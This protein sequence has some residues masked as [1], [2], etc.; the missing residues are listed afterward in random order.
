MNRD[1]EDEKIR[2]WF[3]E[4]KRGDEKLA[5]SFV[6]DWEAARSHV[7]D[8]SQFFPFSAAAV[9][10]MLVFLAAFS[11][12]L[13]RQSARPESPINS[14]NSTSILHWQAPTDFLLQT[15]GNQLLRTAPQIGR[16]AVELPKIN[17][18]GKSR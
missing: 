7:G 12:I 3:H 13:V 5:P 17:F 6:C 10:V 1:R 4:L 2:Q 9:A 14:W 11:W 16:S 15:P 8:R 18:E